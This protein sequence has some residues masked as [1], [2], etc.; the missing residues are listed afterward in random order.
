MNDA[1]SWSKN[2]LF[3]RHVKEV[4]RNAEELMNACEC[5]ESDY[6]QMANEN[7]KLKFLCED[8]YATLVS[9]DENAQDTVPVAPRFNERM[10]RLGIGFHENIDN[11]EKDERLRELATDCLTALQ[12][13][14]DGKVKADCEKCQYGHLEYGECVTT[15]LMDAANDLGIESWR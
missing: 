8:M 7:I 15:A 12:R 13:Y 5:F 1:S 9:I 2:Q 11:D 6:R 10:K 14:C 3:Y 4:T